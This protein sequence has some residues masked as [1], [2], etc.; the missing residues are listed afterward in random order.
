M[1]RMGTIR[2]AKSRTEYRP[3]TCSPDRHRV[4][5]VCSGYCRSRVRVRAKRVSADRLFL[6]RQSV[7]GRRGSGERW[8]RREQS[9]PQPTTTQTEVNDRVR[10]R[11]QT[12]TPQLRWRQAKAGHALERADKNEPEEC[13][14]R[15]TASA[16]SR[17][18]S[19]PHIGFLPQPQPHTPSQRAA[20]KRSLARARFAAYHQMPASTKQRVTERVLR[21]AVSRRPRLLRFHGKPRVHTCGLR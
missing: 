12:L 17:I 14:R 6:T 19:A 9:Q 18:G 20:S 2:Y 3:R 16:Q 21:P 10:T 7:H 8:L 5:S 1:Q 15:R 11:A 4:R 13:T